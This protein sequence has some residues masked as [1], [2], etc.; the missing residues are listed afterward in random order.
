MNISKERRSGMVNYICDSIKDIIV[1]F[2][3]RDPGSEGERKA[4]EY[5]AEELRNYTDEVTIEDFKLHP[6]AFMGWIP[7]T[8]TI[9]LIAYVVSFFI[10]FLTIILIVLALIPMLSQFVLYKQLMD[11]LFPEK[12][13]CNVMAVR[14]PVGEVKRRIVFNGHADATWEWTFNNKFGFKGFSLE[15][16]GSI[17][18]IVYMLIYCIVALAYN[19]FGFK[20]SS[21]VPMIMGLVALVFVPLW[22][23]MYWFSDTKTIV[24]G[25]NDNLTACLMSMAVVKT[26]KEEGIELENTEVCALLSGSEEAGLRGAKAYAKAH[27][28]DFKDCETIFIPM[29]T[30]R[31]IEHL[32]IYSKDLNGLVKCDK[33]VAAL[34]KKAGRAVGHEIHYGTVSVGSTDAAAFTQAGFKA[35]CL[36]AM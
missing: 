26:L 30:L 22:I 14:K 28:D 35:C 16:L 11:P 20:V 25:A 21:G 3:K 4:Q 23:G 2:G 34:L 32:T 13:S 10:P 24:D 31:E 1:K 29:E 9:A 19:G 15:F 6:M 17:L 8:V 36:A 12:V 18:G 5:M 27:K 33:D 7:I